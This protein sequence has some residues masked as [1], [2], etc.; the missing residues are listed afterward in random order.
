M[1]ILIAPL[2]WGLGHAARC[3]PLIHSYLSKGD[4]VVLGGDGDSLLLLRRTFP[5][6]R[7]VDLPSLELRYDEDPQQRGFYWRAIPLLIRFTLADRYYLRQ[8]LAR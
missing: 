7:V 5:D 4:E 3:I 8:V 6:L 2:N 1:K